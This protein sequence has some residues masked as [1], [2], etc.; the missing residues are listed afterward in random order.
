MFA[1]E[2]GRIRVVQ[3]ILFM[4][5]WRLALVLVAL[6]QQ[7]SPHAGVPKAHLLRDTSLVVIA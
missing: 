3:T 4:I 7:S 6:F 1:L 5:W 2:G